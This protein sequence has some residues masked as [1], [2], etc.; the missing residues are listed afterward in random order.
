MA[1]YVTL[2]NWSEQGI[3]NVKDVNKRA[4]VAR[5][6][7]E[8]AGG[9]WIGIWWTQGQYDGV[10]IHEAPD[11]ITATR[12]LMQLGMKGD[13]RTVTLRAFGEEDMERMTQG[14]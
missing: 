9:R 4:V 5:K 8:A 14:L 7:W 10:V 3:K 11:D 2:F 13:V 12:L 6:M 1:A